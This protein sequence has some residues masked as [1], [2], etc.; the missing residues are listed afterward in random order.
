MCWS[1]SNPAES[2]RYHRPI[3]NESA[4]CSPLA[5]RGRANQGGRADSKPAAEARA[6]V[7]A[8]GD[9]SGELRQQARS[10]SNL[11]VEATFVAAFSFINY[12]AGDDVTP[13]MGQWN[14]ELS[15]EQHPPASRPTRVGSLRSGQPMLSA[16]SSAAPLAP[17]FPLVN[18]ERQTVLVIDDDAN[19]ATLMAAIIEAAGCRAI[20]ATNGRTGLG[21]AFECIPDLILCD[22][23]MPDLGGDE[24]MRTL[25]NDPA[26]RDVPRVLM[27]GHGCPDLRAI[28]ADAFIAKP[29]ETQSLRRLLHAFVGGRSHNVPAPV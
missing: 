10:G 4:R 5:A 27:S 12:S 18:D 20:I 24:V 29:I 8:K 9:W 7:E 19:F 21:L 17:M 2:G 14:R 16:R 25:H 3:Q 1:T 15:A 23:S 6:T 22:L 11:I 13:S 28:P 26:M